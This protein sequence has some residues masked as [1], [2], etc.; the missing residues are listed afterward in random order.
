MDKVVFAILTSAMFISMMG[1]G[2]IM[3]L[4]PI[5]AQ[6]MGAS[7]IELG[8]ISAASSFSNLI[9]LPIMGTLSDRFDRKIFLCAGLIILSLVMF[10]FN[11][12]TTTTQLIMLR[13]LQGFAMSMHL[14]VAQAYLGDLTPH[15]EEGRWMGYF[16]AILYAG[17]GAGPLFGGAMNDLFGISSVFYVAGGAILISFIATLLFLKE[18]KKQEAHQRP[19]I[20]FLSLGRSNILKSI[21][22][23][24]IGAGIMT[25]V[26]M[27]FLPILASAGLGLSTTLIGIILAVRTPL[28]MLQTVSGRF[29]DTHNR[30]SQIAVGTLIMAAS[31]ILI[32]LCSDFWQLLMAQSLLAFGV[33]MYQPAASAYVV[34]EGRS[35]GMGAS[36]SLFL[37]AMQGGASIGP[38][39]IGRIMDTYNTAAGFRAAALFN[40]LG[41]G[42][43]L[44]MMRHVSGKKQPVA[45][46]A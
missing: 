9:F 17:V 5:Y 43:F 31:M 15:G 38:I 3:P 44:W 35:F 45:A 18:G 25:G 26:S 36:M 37:M 19:H 10:G 16:N 32:T 34:E 27:T 41:L 28:S 46:R 1:F 29:A 14:P 2:F 4:L 40:T 13:A 6:T 11:W 24:Q 39:V 42:F 22:V 12:A 7:G 33:V 23:L 30:K 8:L 20:P 21:I